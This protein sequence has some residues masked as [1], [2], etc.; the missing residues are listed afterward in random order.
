MYSCITL[1][2]VDYCMILHSCSRE[3]TTNRS[4]NELE[5]AEVYPQRPLA[6]TECLLTKNW[7]Q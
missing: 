4:V 7:W 1:K 6:S 2:P 3:L 5:P